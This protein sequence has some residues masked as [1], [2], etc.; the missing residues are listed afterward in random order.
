[1]RIVDEVINK[2]QQEA[3]ENLKGTN[4]TREDLAHEIIKNLADKVRKLKKENC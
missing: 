4:Y 1:M 3:K 2:A